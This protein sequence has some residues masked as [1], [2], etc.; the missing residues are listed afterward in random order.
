MALEPLSAVILVS[1]IA[2][3]SPAI[4]KIVGIVRSWFRRKKEVIVKISIGPVS[5]EFNTSDPVQVR[6]VINKLHDESIIDPEVIKDPKQRSK[7]IKELRRALDK[8]DVK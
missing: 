7:I 2:A 8:S 6:N 4:V 3:L 1:A 5:I